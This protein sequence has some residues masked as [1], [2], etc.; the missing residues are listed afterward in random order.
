MKK[1]VKN[2]YSFENY[3]PNKRAVAVVYN[4]VRYMSKAQCM[5]LTGISRKDLDTYLAGQQD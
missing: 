1:Q 4:G 5:A 3:K 2:F